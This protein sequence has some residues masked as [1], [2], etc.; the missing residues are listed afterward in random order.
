MPRILFSFAC[1]IMVYAC[2]HTNKVH[3]SLPNAI[4]VLKV[5]NDTGVGTLQVSKLSID[6]TVTGDMATTVFDITFTNPLDRVLEGE[7]EFPLADGQNISRYALDMNGQ[8][9]EGVV[10]E[11]EKARAAYENTIRQNIDPGLVEKTKGN[12]FRTRIYPIP[13]KGVKRVVI[14]VEQQLAIAGGELTYQLPLYL[15]EQLSQFSIQTT[16]QGATAA[17]TLIDNELTGFRFA[18]SNNNWQA[19]FESNGFLPNNTV[20]FSIPFNSKEGSV[21]TGPYHQATA[22]YITTALP[23]NYQEKTA[24]PSAL[25]LWDVSASAAARDMKKEIALMEKYA[26]AVRNQHITLVPFHIAAQQPESF[27]IKN[28]RATELFKRLKELQPDGGTQLGSIDLKKYTAD[29]C[30]LVTEGLSTFGKDEMAFSNIPVTVINSSPSAGHS[31]LKWVALQTNGRYID[32]SSMALEDAANNMLQEPMHF[33]KASYS[34]DEI[35]ELYPCTTNH[36]GFSIAGLLKKPSATITLHFGYGN[37][38]TRSQNFIVKEDAE[39]L[40]TIKKIWASLKIATLDMQYTKNKDAITTLGKEFSIVTQNT[41]LLVLDRVEDYVQYEIEPPAELQKEY[42]S[43]LEGK[44]KKEKLEKDEVYNGALAAMKG[45]KEWWGKKY[46]GRKVTLDRDGEERADTA[47]YVNSTFLG[48]T[49]FSSALTALDSSA[50]SVSANS[51][52]SYLFS[53][54]DAVAET[55]YSAT[56]FKSEEMELTALNKADAKKPSVMAADIELNV[57]KPDMPYL[58][59]LEKTAPANYFAAYLLLKKTY[60]SQPSFFADVARFLFE[61]KQHQLALQV[62]SNINEMKLEDAEL[63]R[64]VANELLEFGESELAVQTFKDILEIRGEHPQ[65]Y[66]DLALAENE[67]GYYDEAVRLLYKVATESWDSRFGEVQQIALNEMNAIISAH[68]SVNTKGINTKLIAAMPVDVRIVIGWSTDN[69]DIDLWVTDPS[70]EKCYY[71]HSETSNGG[72]ISR[73]VTQGFGPEEYSIKK[74][75]NGKYLVEVN[76]FGDRRQTLGGPVTIKAELF[77]NFGRPNQK[78]ETIN[79]RV[80]GNKEVIRI[81]SLIM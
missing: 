41:S 53:T 8:L 79:C 29:E 73:D 55:R 78:R 5:K 43:L 1:L 49:H 33:I 80:A 72:R 21:F 42:Y 19:K 74:A 13:A 56:T 11:K 47:T 81:G 15:K 65:S 22:F 17:P 3:T 63:L 58:K 34:N 18:Q 61:K 2:T 26:E 57:W 45:M 70:K 7:F 60:Q 14:G 76:F 40:G 23:S 31:Y 37:N 48:N 12:N 30:I 9:R 44:H 4:P 52:M 24:A 54:S 10:V 69:S 62:L 67:A 71:G 75:P 59:Q 28:G 64:V 50:A 25:L 68:P 38:I 51:T 16:V 27:E 77:T 39:G 66:R 35:E 20:A 46:S 6:V 36:G 32:L